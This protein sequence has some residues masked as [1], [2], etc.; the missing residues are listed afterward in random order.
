MS[1]LRRH[2]VAVVAA[3]FALA[4]GIA[5]GG[6]PLS[7]V[8]PDPESPSTGDVDT[9]DEAPEVEGPSATEEFAT[10]FAAS[11]APLVY[12]SRLRGH[13]TAILAMPGADPEVVQGMVTQVKAAGGGLTG[14]F[15]LDDQVTALSGTSLVDTLGSQL[16][17]QLDAELDEHRVD[18][19]ASTYVRFGQLLG[20]AV[21]TPIKG[22]AHSD[23]SAEAIRA[24]LA[25]AGML[26]SPDEARL[27][28]LLLV[29]LPPHDAGDEDLLVSAGVYRGL[30]IGL[31]DTPAGVVVLGDT[32]SGESGILAELREDEDVTVAVSTVDG[33]DTGVGQVTAMLALIEGLD[34]TVGSY[35][36]SGA[37]G[38]VPI[39]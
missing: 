18:P 30:T 20:L 6:G 16:M 17:T 7:Y 4:V 36:A 5:L 10:V 14:V 8:H 13:P 31:A 23:P 35:G 25:E 22:G 9:P 37:D 12:D 3:L 26:T 19:S 21:G 39:T 29:V 24:A 33:S 28:P 34:A 11:V 38:A 15:E 32:A 1:R 2:V 27:A